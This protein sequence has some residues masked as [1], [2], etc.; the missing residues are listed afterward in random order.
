MKQVFCIRKQ[1][2]H[3]GPARR[4]RLAASLLAVLMLAW[5]FPVNATA[6]EPL[7]VFH[8]FQSGA[9]G[10]DGAFWQAADRHAQEH[11]DSAFE[12]TFID[13]VTYSEMLNIM[14]AGDMK[15]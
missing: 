14:M 2:Q 3:T 4:R 5:L 7:T 10:P 9:A 1:K 8:F 15:Q 12:F 11:P 6:E 13:S